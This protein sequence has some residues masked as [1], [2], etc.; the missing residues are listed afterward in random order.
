MRNRKLL[1][2]VF[3]RGMRYNEIRLN[4]D[5]SLDDIVFSDGDMHLEQMDKNVW[6]LLFYRKRKVICFDIRAKTPVTVEVAWET[7]KPAKRVSQRSG[8]GKDV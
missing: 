2:Y 1:N 4:E 8:G 3:E 7:H 5:G 6:S